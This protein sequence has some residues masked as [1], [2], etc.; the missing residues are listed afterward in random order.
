M[1]TKPIGV[2]FDE[3]LLKYMNDNGI[4][5]PQAALNL[6]EQYYI[7]SNGIADKLG[8]PINVDAAIKQ[9]AKKKSTSI[10]TVDIQPIIDKMLSVSSVDNHLGDNAY[11]LKYGRHR[12]G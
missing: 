7:N 11:F 1:K 3:T 2:R 10:K 8:K 4:T 9:V 5:T 6:L 12:G